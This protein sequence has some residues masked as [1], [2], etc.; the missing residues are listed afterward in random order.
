MAVGVPAQMTLVKTVNPK[1][2]PGR[3]CVHVINSCHV[4]TVIVLHREQRLTGILVF[5]LTGL[6]VFL[7][8]VLQVSQ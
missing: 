4:I 8:P 1:L 2:L 7:A 6:S 3:T 5:V